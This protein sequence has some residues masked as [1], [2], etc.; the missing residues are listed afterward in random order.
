MRIEIFTILLWIISVTCAAAQPIKTNV[1]YGGTGGDPL[2]V[3]VAKEAALFEKNGLDARLI[4]FAG[5]TTSVLA[6]I[7]GDVQIGQVAGPSVVNSSMGGSDLV[8][9]AG[10]I[11]SLNYWIMGRADIKSSEQL[12][13]GAIAISRFGS[14]TDFIARFALPKMALTPGRDVAIVQIGDSPARLGALLNGKVQ[15]AVLGSL[16][17]ALA[18]K[19]GMNILA[20][21]A[22]MGLVIQHTG[23][24]TTRK[25]IRENREL[26]KRYVKT[27]I[28]AVHRIW[29]DRDGTIN[30]FLKHTG[31]GV[32]RDL[33]EKIREAMLNEAMLSKKQYPSIPGI[34]TILNSMAETDPRAR[35]AKPEEFV[36]TSFIR[37]LDQSG[38]IDR[39]YATQTK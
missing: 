14:A 12:R 35:I 9:V 37:E 23:V 11:T 26:V 39:L 20:D 15:G 16:P 21:V 1:A 3:I 8:M 4:Y 17:G 36:D 38:Y 31:K 13:G 5:G 33:L 6:L 25:M 19:Q 32:E 24:A 2:P 34:K 18:Q 30:A 28:D 29:T 22:K 7:S 10:G 27:Q